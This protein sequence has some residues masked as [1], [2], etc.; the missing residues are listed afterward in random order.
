MYITYNKHKKSPNVQRDFQG[1]TLIFGDYFLGSQFLSFSTSSPGVR[2]SFPKSLRTF[3][4]LPR[5]N[6]F[7]RR[8]RW[9]RGNT[10]STPPRMIFFDTLHQ[11]GCIPPTDIHIH[12]RLLSTGPTP[13][14]V[15]RG[16]P[17]L[18][19]SSKRE[20]GSRTNIGDRE[21]WGWVSGC[22]KVPWPRTSVRRDYGR[23]IGDRP[24]CRG[25]ENRNG[26]TRV[27]GHRHGDP[28]GT[29][30]FS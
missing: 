4:D 17:P 3:Q 18:Y 21:R 23:V 9:T 1:D 13:K 25:L 26:V 27:L 16:P 11:R 2:L 7:S 8:R 30:R 29:G 5:R 20:R 6:W 14:H 19:Y 15:F 24:S 22:L 10:K 12:N 28:G